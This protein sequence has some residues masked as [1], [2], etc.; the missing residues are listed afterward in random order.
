MELWSV[1]AFITA[2]LPPWL[3][4]S[5]VSGPHVRSEET[6]PIFKRNA[7]A[8]GLLSLNKEFPMA[9]TQ[10]DKTGDKNDVTKKDM[11]QSQQ[12]QAQ[13]GQAQQG[14][15]Q[16]DKAKQEQAQQ[17]ETSRPANR[18]QQ[19]QSNQDNRDEAKGAAA[20]SQTVAKKKDA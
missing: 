16:Q 20:S 7:V 3:V 18:Q 9:T 17:G 6:L 19:S 10:A 1:A 4:V 5:A 14:Q 13:Q 2:T 8:D 12:G 15:A 11:S